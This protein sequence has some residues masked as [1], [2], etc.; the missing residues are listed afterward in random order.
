VYVCVCVHPNL[1]AFLTLSSLWRR[2]GTGQMWIGKA[3][4]VSVFGGW[5]LQ[6]VLLAT[7]VHRLPLTMCVCVFALIRLRFSLCPLFGATRGG[8]RGIGWWW[9]GTVWAVSGIGDWPSLG[10]LLATRVLWLPPFF[11]PIFR[12]FLSPFRLYHEP[13]PFSPPLFGAVVV[14]DVVRYSAPFA[15]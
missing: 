13:N 5:P 3:C 12:T 2:V 9:I 4:A 6:G 15:I 1:Y 8:V 7:R 14:C 11:H 10:V